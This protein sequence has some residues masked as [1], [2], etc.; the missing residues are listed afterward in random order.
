MAWKSPVNSASSAWSGTAVKSSL[1]NCSVR[2]S[3]LIPVERGSG[4]VQDATAA[5]TTAVVTALPASDWSNSS[6][7]KL[8]FESARDNCERKTTSAIL[9]LFQLHCVPLVL[10]LIPSVKLP[11]QKDA[12]VAAPTGARMQTDLDRRWHCFRQPSPTEHH[13]TSVNT[14][15][16]DHRSCCENTHTLPRSASSASSSSSSSSASSLLLSSRMNKLPGYK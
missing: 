7:F 13:W 9:D 14:A 4:L 12:L 3:H 10:Q 2:E 8:N 6:G 5:I 11:E 15:R 16:N 1:D